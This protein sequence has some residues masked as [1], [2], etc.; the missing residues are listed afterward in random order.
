M[1]MDRPTSEQQA[2]TGLRRPPK[3][4]GP[5]RGFSGRR[6]GT[7]G[8]ARLVAGAAAWLTLASA[9]PNGALAQEPLG[10]GT[11]D[12]PGKIGFDRPE[13]W[14]MKYFTS[15][16]LLTGLGVPGAV[17]EGN[18]VVALE[19][20]F[21]PTLSDEQRTVG[22]N[23]V[24]LEDLNKTSAF[25]RIRV[26][27]GLTGDAE[28]TLAWVPPLKLNGAQPN[29]FSA[30]VGMPILYTEAARIG[31]RVYGQIGSVS[32]DFTCD[33]ETVA[34]GDD[35]T[36]NPYGCERISD[37]N[38]TQQ[39]LGVELGVA[40][41][42]GTTVEPYVTVGGNRFSTRF[43]T[44]ALTRGTL[45]RST[46]ET[47]GYTVHATG[48]VSVRINQR[49]RVV[50]EAFYTP[51]GVQRFG[52]DSASNDGLFNGRGMVEIRF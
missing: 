28:F 12:D 10:Y 44:N 47:S 36:L 8:S 9:M 37:D 31:L 46:F 18:V 29:L 11:P 6:V 4:G 42:I 30:A 51:L 7:L 17:G 26:T 20:G 40:T 45:D 2:R 48:G 13:S 1:R 25:G 33:A 14:A 16:S 43:E 21:I 35:G 32:G 22:F 50:G 27:L 52:T 23:G 5:R 34:A 19:G 38:T 3:R 15:V 39:Y 41:E 49:V 24:K